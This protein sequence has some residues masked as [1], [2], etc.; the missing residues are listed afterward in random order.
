M[1]E[2][3]R[4][5]VASF[6]D[7][8]PRELYGILR[9]RSDVF[10]VEQ[11]CAYADIDGDDSEPGAQQLWIETDGDV[12]STVRVLRTA[13]GGSII[14]RVA[15]RATHRGRGY[16]SLL[17]RRALQLAQRPV[18]LKAQA[19]L[20]PWYGGFGFAV[21]GAEFMEDGIAHVPMRLDVR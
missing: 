2:A 4:I 3:P 20:A 16:A 8:R 6:A 13:G 11:A 9:V 7:L 15:T 1:D 21:C 14:G 12:V 10:I 5:H 17:M 19:Y 18:V